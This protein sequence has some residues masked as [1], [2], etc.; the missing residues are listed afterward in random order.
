MRAVF[1]AFILFVF[2][3]A[4]AQ[5]DAFDSTEYVFGLPV[6]NDDTT[7]RRFP[8]QPPKDV[9]EK[10]WDVDIPKRLHKALDQEN[11]FKGWRKYGVYRDKNTGL[12]IIYIRDRNSTQVYGLNDKGKPVTYNEVTLAKDSIK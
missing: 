3:Y 10:V 12:Y 8:D 1:V 5:S 2:N 11:L 9:L 7:S 4:N 6:T